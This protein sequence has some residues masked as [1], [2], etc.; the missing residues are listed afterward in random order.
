MKNM[1]LAT[2][3]ARAIYGLAKEKNEQD[4]VFEQMRVFE[5]A[6]TSDQELVAFIESPLYRPSD[7]V[8]AL[9]A[10]V[11]KVNASDVLKNFVLL[12]ARKN[13][14]G[15]FSDVMTAYQTISDEAHGVTRGLVR[16][17]A[18]LSPE[19]RKNIEQLVSKAT[20]KQVILTYKEDPSLLGGLVA[21]VGSFTFDDSLI[22]HLK[23]INEQLTQGSSVRN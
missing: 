1:I 16:S 20:K 7:K 22:S 6:F 14:L 11:G 5:Q 19:D 2:R 3:Y 9:E 15:I 18:V 8:K 21:E 10:V 12:L 4:S 13:R 23:R 17:A